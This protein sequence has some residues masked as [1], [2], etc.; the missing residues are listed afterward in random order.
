MAC[1]DVSG[2]TLDPC[3]V[4]TARK[5]E[6]GLLQG[7]GRVRPGTQVRVVGE[8]GEIIRI[9]WIYVNTGDFEIPNMRSRLDAK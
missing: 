5:T 3:K 1:D 2:A 6:D 4:H 8:K 7:H 9:K